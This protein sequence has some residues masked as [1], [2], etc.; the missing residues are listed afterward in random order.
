MHVAG[1]PHPGTPKHKSK[2]ITVLIEKY[3]FIS[4]PTQ[5]KP[6]LFKCQLINVH[7]WKYKKNVNVKSHNEKT[8]KLNV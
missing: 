4:G 1:P 5:F 3:L 2:S 8:E 6:V 7:I